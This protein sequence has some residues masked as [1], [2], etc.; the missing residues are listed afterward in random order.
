MFNLMVTAGDGLWEEGQYTWHKSRIF[1]HTDEKL[2]KKFGSLSE[3]AQKAL[4]SLPTLFM[5][6]TGAKGRAKV[7]WVRKIQQ[8]GAEFRIQFEFDQRFPSVTAKQIKALE[9]DLGIGDWEMNRTH[10]AVKDGSLFEILGVHKAPKKSKVRKVPKAPKLSPAPAI[11]DAVDKFENDQTLEALIGEIQRGM[12]EN[13]HAECLD[14]LHT[15][16]MKKFAHLLKKRE[17]P[18][19]KELPLHSRV[20]MYVKEL[21]KTVTLHETSKR[22]IKSS[23]SVF[24]EFNHVRNNLSLAHDNQLLDQAEARFVFD[25]IVGILRFVKTLEEDNF[26]K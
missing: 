12:R 20:G 22:I 23:I 13:R 6:E 16:C 3:K 1:E 15:Y 18:C 26:E 24:E 25:S 9:W 10:W 21:E 19:E 7:G 8:R 2:I 5:Y 4:L 11:H 17:I 14:R